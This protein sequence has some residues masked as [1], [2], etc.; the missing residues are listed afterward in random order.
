MDVVP[1]FMVH[2]RGHSF[3]VKLYLFKFNLTPVWLCTV[4]GNIR[5]KLTVYE[6]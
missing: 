1:F 2:G 5:P 4:C 6:Y 3:P